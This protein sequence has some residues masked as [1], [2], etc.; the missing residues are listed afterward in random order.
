M[1]RRAAHLSMMVQ[2]LIF[3]AL[4]LCAVSICMICVHLCVRKRKTTL[5]MVAPPK[6]QVNAKVCVQK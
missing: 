3:V 5:M 4:C 2:M 6:P 1:A